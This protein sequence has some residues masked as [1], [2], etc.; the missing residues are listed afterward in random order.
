MSFTIS[1]DNDFAF[2]L[3]SEESINII[4]NSNINEKGQLY[5]LKDNYIFQASINDNC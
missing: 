3:I 4:G 5:F 2:D 1:F